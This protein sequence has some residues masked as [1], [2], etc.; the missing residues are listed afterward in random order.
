MGKISTYAIDALPTLDDKVIG[1]D[2]ENQ[3]ITK[4][5]LLGDII[6]LVPTPT[7]QE[8]LD[9]GNVATQNIALT[10][11]I[12]TDYMTVGSD[13]LV[14]GA[15][16][17]TG[18]VTA[19][20][21]CV[22]EDGIVAQGAVYDNSGSPGTAGQILYTTTS[23]V[24]W[25]TPPPFP[26]DLQSV[27]DTGNTATQDITLNGAVV[28]TVSQTNNLTVN[29]DALVSH[30]LTVVGVTRLD[31]PLEDHYSSVGTAGQI[32]SSTGADVKW[33]D[34]PVVTVPSLTMVLSATSTATSQVPSGQLIPMQVE[35]G[36]A[37]GTGTDPVMIDGAG[38]ITFN[39]TGSYIVNGFGNIERQGSSGGVAVILFRA[40]VNGTQAGITRVVELDKPDE[41]QPYDLS[42][43][44]N[45]GSAPTKLTFEIMRDSN[46]INDGGLYN[47]VVGGGTWSTVPTAYVQVWKLA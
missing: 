23:G 24:Q 19:K 30:D 10:G 13:L 3:Q 5:Y 43:P 11:T 33:I 39:Q 47:H 20:S 1:T 38:V 46:G 4:N 22:F 6:G 7:L 32:L 36:A 44:I 42:I 27:L 28:S 17:F 31:G 26:A 34:A 37:Q 25:Q 16:L 15:T 12:V 18:Y 40:L 29:N 9:S 41:V 8:V 35:F 21:D 2:A 14:D 45:I